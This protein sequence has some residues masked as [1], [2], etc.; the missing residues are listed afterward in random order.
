MET[1]TTWEVLGRV[2]ALQG[3]GGRQRERRELV[4][5]GTTALPSGDYDAES[6]K[7]PPSECSDWQKST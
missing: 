1:L 2:P 3:A 7:A 4:R 6:W 5:A